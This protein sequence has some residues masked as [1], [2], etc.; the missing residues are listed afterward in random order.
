MR[1]PIVV[2]AVAAAVFTAVA[3]ALAA[4]SASRPAAAT[5]TVAHAR[6]AADESTRV[7]TRRVWAGDDVNLDG[8]PS[9]DGRYLSFVDAPGGDLAIRDLLAGQNRRVTNGGTWSDYSE[10]SAFSP[11]GRRLVYTWYR[12]SIRRYELRLIGVDGSGPRVLV[13]DS[14]FA[15]FGPPDWSANGR[16]IA[17]VIS[18]S[19]RSKALALVAVET[20]ALRILR[21]FDWRG[22]G[23]VRWPR[24]SKTSK[25]QS[26]SVRASGRIST[27]T[28]W[29]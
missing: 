18:R 21:S 2:T 19:D 27:I 25:E 5:G 10:A 20:G 17:V 12:N 22:P 3:A 6:P 15:W 26:S 14:A 24:P 4:R 28:R 8:A 16:D 13:S 29:R 7:V 11:D 1:R 23:K 9:P